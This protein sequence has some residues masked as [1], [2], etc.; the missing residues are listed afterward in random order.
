[1]LLQDH[2]PYK[3]VENYHSKSCFKNIQCPKE[4]LQL[5]HRKRREQEGPESTES[6]DPIHTV[7]YIHISL[8]STSC[9]AEE[10]QVDPLGREYG[11]IHSKL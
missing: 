10:Q 3:L 5:V 2:L 4:T 1:V 6:S 11:T 8:N 9:I 7:A